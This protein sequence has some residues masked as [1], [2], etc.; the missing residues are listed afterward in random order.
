MLMPTKF[1]HKIT[2]KQY[3]SVTVLK[4]GIVDADAM[5]VRLS[6]EADLGEWSNVYW[7]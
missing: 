2:V 4:Q 1:E 7:T 3:I 5:H 6:G